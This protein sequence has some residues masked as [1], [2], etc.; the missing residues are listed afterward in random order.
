M[1]RTARRIRIATSLAASAA[2]ALTA[3]GCGSGSGGSDGGT[4][5][6]KITTQV[7]YGYRGAIYKEFEKTHPGIKV[8]E[9]L[10]D[11]LPQKLV[12]QLA[13][14]RG[15]SDVVGLGDDT[16][17][18][19]KPSYAK[20][21]NLADYGVDNTKDPWADWAYQ[22]G[23]VNNGAFVLG[24]RTD[25]GGMGICYRTDLFKQAGLPTDPGAV[26]KLWPTWAD[27]T[28]TGQKFAKKVSSASFTANTGDIWVAMTNQHKETFFAE[29]DDSFIADTNTALKADFLTAADM[30]VKKVS[31][32]FPP[33]SPEMAA[34]LKNG[35][36][37]TAVCPAWKL[38][39][40]KEASGAA[41][42]GK[43]SVASA[44]GGGN[45]GGSYLA[46][47]KQTAH[48]KEAAELARWLTSSAT[49]KKLFLAKGYLSSHPDVYKDPEVL[50]KKDTY[51]SDAPTGEIFAKA[52]DSIQPY[53]RGT[54]DS[55]ISGLFVNALL[56]VEQGK[57]SP[58][59][60]W[61]QAISDSKKVL[62]Q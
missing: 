49:Q 3:A 31:G 10:V 61:N 6:L 33:F 26:A 44:P 56:R 17:T 11:D 24:V 55:D 35:K 28:A 50:A 40:T 62:G 18:K 42:S 21:L 4:V 22:A 60:S 30:A 52:A 37:A 38:D 25:I 45:W 12:T 58:E 20:F 46:V 34:A 39:R 36:A 57:Q 16:L 53:Y 47:P 7:D 51:F 54:H 41:N 59:D 32:G 5:T 15:A 43:W 29:S 13:A 9:V 48:P 2:L 27:F 23:T 1:P 19:F 14:G 8:K